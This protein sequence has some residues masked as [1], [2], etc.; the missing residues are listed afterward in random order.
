LRSFLIQHVLASVVL[1]AAGFALSG[2]GFGPDERELIASARDNVAKKKPDAAILQLK[3]ALQKNGQSAEARFLL[4]EAL[5]ATGVPALAVVEFEK[6][7]DLQ[8]PP[9]AVVP[10]LAR[11]L[12]ASGQAKKVADT[13]GQVNLADPTAAADLKTTLATAYGALGQNDLAEAAVK[14][15]LKLN[16][17]NSTARLQQATLLGRRFAADEALALVDGVIADEPKRREAWQLKGELLLG[18]KGDADAGVRAYREALAIDPRFLPAHSALITLALR[19]NDV[20][21]F[22][23]QFGELQKALPK[24]PETLY[25]QAQ[26]ALSEGDVKGAREQITQLLRTAPDNA[27]LQFLAGSAEMRA[28]ALLLAETHLVKAVQL[29]PE[30]AAARLL[31]ARTYLRSGQTDRIFPLLDPLL[32]RANPDAA[33][34]DLAAEAHLQNGD[35]A[36]A[37]TLFAQVAKINPNDPRAQTALAL[38]QINKGNAEAGLALLEATA[39]RDSGTATDLALIGVRIRRNELDAALKAIDRLQAKAADKP[40]PYNL[41]GR[42]LALRKDAAGARASFERAVSVDAVFTPAILSLAA[43]DV[44]E[45]KPDDARKRLE[46]LL[47][48][49]AKNYRVL[50]ALV[51]VQ[52]SLGAKPEDIG[53]LLADAV[54]LN[55]AE[56]TPRLMLIDHRLRQQDLKGANDAAQEAVAAVPDNLQLIDALG[57][58]QLAAG[59]AQQAITAFGRVAAAQPTLS[60]PQL[61]LADAYLQAKDVPAAIKALRRAVEITPNLLP[62]QRGLISIATAEKRFDDAVAGAR[63]IQKQRPKDPV[64]FMVESEVRLVQK[65]WDPAVAAMRAALDRSRST[66]IATFLHVLYGK[67]G[68]SADAERFAAEWEKSFPRDA[69]FQTHLA[70]SAIGRSDLAAAEMRFRKV[71]ALRPDDP[72]ALNNLAWTLL[73]QGKGGA[74]PMAQRAVELQP[75]SAAMMDTLALALAADNQLP[76]AIE[77]QRK[78]VAK[79]PEA[80]NF[81][82]GLAKLLVKTGDKPAARTELDTLAKLGNKFAGQ[83]EVAALLKLL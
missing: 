61:Q 10:L 21:A 43:M 1:I 25:Y 7:R 77:W 5:L 74:L 48:R 50:L 28:G 55:P 46:A 13:Y 3:S 14:A 32:K 33:A 9:E 35:L 59:Q 31:L 11:A 65:Q 66:E 19:N 41:R 17:K 20:P 30:L 49:E 58:T 18:G 76:K 27:R 16:P 60:A 37:E 29:A 23:A 26:L 15:A 62:A 4:G 24:H 51:D 44:A 38:A 2:C 78:A 52:R 83:A 40:L 8:H 72:L 47:A 70:A 80:P 34:L 63:E 82:L 42:V 69:A 6:A 71:A 68:R 45:K 81:R 75:G 36:R 67:A 54:K 22:K 12:V 64:G 39:A 79:A 53:K 73:A 57:R 56:V